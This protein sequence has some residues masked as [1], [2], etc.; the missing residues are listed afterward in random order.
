MTLISCAREKEIA[1]LLERGQWPHV[2]PHD[3]LA[4]VEGCRSC[5]ELVL[6]RQA[7]QQARDASMEM[8]ALPSASALWWRAQLRKRNEAIERIS[9]PIL[10]AE[11]FAFAVVALVAVCG[12]A[13]LARRG[14]DFASVGRAAFKPASWLGALWPSSLPNFALPNFEGGLWFVVPLLATL[15]IVSGLVVYFASEKQ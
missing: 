8:P 15:A 13:W 10:G 12:A 7:F 1:V 3:L 14:F 2:A 11:I 9:K 4:H 5:S 6:T